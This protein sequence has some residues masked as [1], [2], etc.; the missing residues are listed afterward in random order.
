MGARIREHPWATTS[1]GEPQA[2]PEALRT[3]VEVMLGSAQPMFVAWGPERI[4]LYNDSY[5]P[6]CGARHPGALGRQFCDVWPN[7]MDVLGPVLDR[8]YAGEPTHMDDI[9]VTLH[10]HG[11]SEKANFAFSYTPVRDRRGAVTGIFGVCTET[12]ARVV[13]ERRQAFL[14]ALEER[15]RELADP[16]EIMAAAAETLGTHLGASCVG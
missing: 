9:A 12:T 1:L 11:R 8:A 10:R 4:M 6:I 7:A 15:L 14:L 13:A 3:L 2:W 5:A 16:R